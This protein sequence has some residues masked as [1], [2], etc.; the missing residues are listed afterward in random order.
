MTSVQSLYEEALAAQLA[1]KNDEAIQAYHA[2]LAEAPA[3]AEGNHNLGLLEFSRGNLDQALERLMNAIEARPAESQFWHSLLEVLL[4]AGAAGHAVQMLE[5]A[6]GSGIT[7]DELQKMRQRIEAATA[8]VV[9]EAPVAGPVKL[10]ADEQEKELLAAVAQII[11]RSRA[12]M[13]S[14]K[15]AA[16]KG[17][18]VDS[19]VFNRLVELFNQGELHEL[20][21]R[22]QQ[23]TKTHPL[24]PAGWHFLGMAHFRLGERMSALKSL[25]KANEAFP[26]DAQM[27]DHLGSA[28]S[29]FNYLAEAEALFKLSLEIRPSKI[30]TLVRYGNMEVNR[31]AFDK[32]E[33]LARKA[34]EIAPGNAMACQL[35][36][37][38]LLSTRRV[39]EA[40]P[41]LERAIQADPS[42]GGAYQDLGYAYFNQGRLD[43]SIRTSEQAVEHNPD[44][45][46]TYSN[47]LFFTAHDYR[48]SPEDVFEQHLEFGRRFEVPLLSTHR[49]HENDRDPERRLRIGFVSG[50]FYDHAVASFIEPV[51]KNLDTNRFDLY[52]FHNTVK[53]DAISERLKAL[54]K[55]W[56]SIPHVSDKDVA[57]IVR[58]CR[59]D[60]LVD[61]SGHTAGHRL[62]AFARK[63]APL[64][65]SWIGYPNTTGL[66]SMDYHFADR[67][68]S[69]EGLFDH[70]F[71]EQIVRL[72]S[73]GTFIHPDRSP[74]V[75]ALPALSNGHLTFGSFNRLGKV[76]APTFDLWAR[77]MRECPDARM[78]LGAV[79]SESV[80]DALR[81]EFSKRGVAGDR[82]RFE[83]RKPMLDY[84]KL[85]NEVDLILDTFPYPGG[86]T[87]NLAVWMG[88][89][90]LTMQ[91]NSRI[92]HGGA[93]AMSRIG[94]DDFIAR[95]E[96]DFVSRARQIAAAPETLVELRAGL[97]QRIAE[98]PYRDIRFVTRGLERAFRSIWRDWC[99]GL[100]PR[101][102]QIPDRDEE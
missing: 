86:T 28:L 82:L 53:F 17:R 67:F 56:V 30:D 39:D 100:A 60:I 14:G 66:V 58:A 62:L 52:A 19:K 32:G 40:I 79:P 48:L 3:H 61:L 68:N 26:A 63:P 101:S 73:N 80:A 8:P 37:L 18:P 22:A 88:V 36:A 45:P 1:G 6:A 47:L 43:D 12:Q 4:A 74:G 33:G 42:F 44:N 16:I 21:K 34:V 90:V 9:E 41:Y 20:E 77:V 2:L 49:P 59:I 57:E 46:N 97:R 55:F 13:A 98:C 87:S 71:T 31:R 99:A 92:S 51:L 91:G 81:E 94:L 35:M 23:L 96:D 27:L 10:A 70:L 89:P 11:R 5:Q 65:V 72:P 29:T 50:D 64:Q 69:P 25:V 93:G 75:N 78:L 85:H 15:R 83:L 38:V 7:E 102:R 84:L 95:D 54:F 24:N 76:S